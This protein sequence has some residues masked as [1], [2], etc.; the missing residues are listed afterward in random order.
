MVAFCARTGV[1]AV[2][3]SRIAAAFS[4]IKHFP[5]AFREGV[6]LDLRI[7][8]FNLLNHPQFGTPGADFNSPA[9]FGVVNSTVNNPRL[10]QFALKLAF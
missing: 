7:E 9:T 1:P 10:F 6:R 3:A 4:L 2:R 5:L 8:V